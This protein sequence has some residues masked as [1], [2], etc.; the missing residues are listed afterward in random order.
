MSSLYFGLGVFCQFEVIVTEF[1]CTLYRGE[2][3]DC[4]SYSESL[5][6]NRQI[7]AIPKYNDDIFA[8]LTIPHLCRNGI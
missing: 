2:G 5:A 6:S 1:V 7:T 8:D 4:M 3:R